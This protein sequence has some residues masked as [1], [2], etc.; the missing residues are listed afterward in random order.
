[1][2]IP[3]DPRE[4]ADAVATYGHAAY[5][6]TVDA[7]GR[8]RVTHVVVDIDGD[9]VRAVLG[10]SA[11]GNVSERPSVTV[12]WPAVEADGYSLIADG[13]ADVVAD[14]ESDAQ[15]TIVVGSAVKHRPAPV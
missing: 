3:V 7:D 9:R 12:L 5:V 10:R 2:T 15:V 8:P 1:M 6:L 14:P 11:T 4:L 13:T